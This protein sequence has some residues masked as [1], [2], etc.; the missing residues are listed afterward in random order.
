MRVSA[1]SLFKAYPIL[2]GLGVC[3]RHQSREQDLQQQLRSQSAQV[4]DKVRVV[5]SPLK[6]EPFGS[7]GFRVET[8]FVFLETMELAQVVLGAVQREPKGRNPTIT[9]RI[10]M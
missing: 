2:N 6:A 7:S 3:V 8:G 10:M 1:M 9:I 5:Q 4:A